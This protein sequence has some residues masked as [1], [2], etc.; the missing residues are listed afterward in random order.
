MELAIKEVL[1]K[2]RKL[3]LDTRPLKIQ[4]FIGPLSKQYKDSIEDYNEL[5]KFTDNVTKMKD[6]KIKIREVLDEKLKEQKKRR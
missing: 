4:D 6:R 5:Q 2:R 1:T 3:K